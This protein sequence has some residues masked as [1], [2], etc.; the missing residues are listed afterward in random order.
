MVGR[1]LLVVD[2]QVGDVSVTILCYEDRQV[3]VL[4]GPEQR[5]FHYLWFDLRIRGFY[6]LSSGGR[7][8]GHPI[9]RR[10]RAKHFLI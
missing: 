5:P 7:V 1:A 8:E 9:R 6:G 4:P 10:G 2:T 3:V